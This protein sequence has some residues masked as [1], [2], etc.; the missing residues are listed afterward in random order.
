[1]KFSIVFRAYHEIFMVVRSYRV[2]VADIKSLLIKAVV[3]LETRLKVLILAIFD[4]FW[5][6]SSCQFWHKPG[7]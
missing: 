5:H 6:I 7:Q 1:M 3:G 2:F 4:D